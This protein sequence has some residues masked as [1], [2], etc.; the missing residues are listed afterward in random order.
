[1]NSVRLPPYPR[2]NV[3]NLV[4][5]VIPVAGVENEQG[6]ATSQGVC[7]GNRFSL[8]D[9]QEDGHGIVHSPIPTYNSSLSNGRARSPNLHVHRR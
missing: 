9:V 8:M 5:Q 6:V 4:G 1:M 2:R 3:S 7:E